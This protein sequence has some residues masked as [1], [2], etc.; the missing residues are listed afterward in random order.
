MNKK[1]IRIGAINW[2]SC[3][4]RD[5][6]FGSYTLKALGN[7]TYKS[8]LPYFAK[9]KNGEYDFSYRTQ[10]E[11]DR[12]LL[13]AVEA[14]IDFFAYCWYPDTLSERTCWKDIGSKLLWEHYPELNIARKLYQ[15]SYVNKDIKMCAIL[16]TM[17]AYA[18]TD[19][20]DLIFAM[21]QDYYE[22][23]DGRP[24]IFTF[25]GFEEEF[26]DAI[27]ERTLKHNIN[28]YIVF[29]NNSATIHNGLN[30]RKA[31][32]ISA[33]SSC[34]N[35][36]SFGD[37]INGV[38]E[39]N[40]KRLES[41]L[42]EIPMLSVG[43]NPIYYKG[44]LTDDT[45]SDMEICERRLVYS[46]ANPK[47]EEVEIRVYNPSKNTVKD[48]ISFANDLNKA[49]LTDFEGRV[50]SECKFKGSSISLTLKPYE[51]ATLRVAFK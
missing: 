5:T 51:I 1:N 33:Y 3:L 14:G 7:D 43:W 6:Y 8:R 32:A 35:G 16:F 39:N 38:E 37:V 27:K 45:I 23:I 12:E 40:Y 2:D 26:I 34:H 21:K 4:P 19:I 20:D 42:K 18:E 28:P 30:Y 11:Y 13:Y 41:G 9:E 44:K 49:E 17:R 24:V 15:K 31:D 46:T 50:L 29:M 25:G 36:E 48:E 47:G 10:E 22:K